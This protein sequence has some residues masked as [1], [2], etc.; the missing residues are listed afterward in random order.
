MTARA[1]DRLGAGGWDVVVA[2]ARAAGAASALLLARAGLRVL[3][4]DPSRPGSDTLSTH[5][6]MRSAVARL[7]AWGLL[8]EVRDAGTPP[9]RRTVFR[10]G[11]DEVVVPIEPRGPVDALYAPRR[12]LLDPLL[13]D[14][15]RRAGATVVH[16][17]AVL[18][19]LRDP[20]GGRVRGARVGVDGRSVD[21]PARL[22]IGADG[23]RSRVARL[24][25]SEAIH[26]GRHATASV[27]GYWP[28]PGI[29]GYLWH[30][31]TDS[32]V[33]FIPTG[34]G[35]VC[36]F[37]SLPAGAFR[38]S[39]SA[40]LQRLHRTLL[41]LGAP[42]LAPL[43]RPDAGVRLRAFPGMPGFLRR[44]I[45]PGWA[46]V[47]DAGYF[48]DPLAAHGISD[49]LR[50]AELLAGAAV[51][52]LAEDDDG[53]LEAYPQGRDGPAAD[54]LDL[55]DRIA[56]FEWTMEELPALHLELSRQM[57]RRAGGSA[58][59]ADRPAA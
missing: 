12:T 51:R 22:V 54:F 6:L 27:Y 28:N 57:R 59:R 42:E 8:E 11:E 21:V 5:A 40:G 20:A 45:G 23:L 43:L 26:R 33:G 3:V 55:T 30:Y 46:L 47:G 1:L 32:S 16:G 10:Y 31:R 50:D 19:L 53:A 48:R 2:G 38:V 39:G 35:E 56:S 4:V 34:G 37:A 36:V 7:A 25:G 13:E 14:A 49:A 24:V 58:P 29:D 18:D 44:P 9:I 17:A 41:E 52:A 15:A